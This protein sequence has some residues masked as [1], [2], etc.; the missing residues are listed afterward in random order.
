MGQ[1]WCGNKAKVGW[2]WKT[3]CYCSSVK[4]RHLKWQQLKTKGL[5]QF[6]YLNM[7]SSSI[8]WFAQMEHR[9]EITKQKF[10][11]IHTGAIVS[12]FFFSKR[13]VLP[14]CDKS[15]EDKDLCL[16]ANTGRWTNS[17]FNRKSPTFGPL[18][19]AADQHHLHVLF[20]TKHGRRVAFVCH[21]SLQ[22]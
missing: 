12:F 17:H 18:K 3:W 9:K 11:T 2:L 1:L 13:W 14:K 7:R 22:L 8:L 15:A 4:K 20:V 6:E 10:F 16:P 5:P 21:F 19:P